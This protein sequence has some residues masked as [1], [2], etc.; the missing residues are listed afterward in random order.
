MKK[1]VFAV[2]LAAGVVAGFAVTTPRITTHRRPV[3]RPALLERMVNGPDIIGMVSWG[4]N[5]YT[6]KEWGY[7]DVDPNC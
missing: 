2:V 1:L 5:T 7:G 3:P 6:D 4:L